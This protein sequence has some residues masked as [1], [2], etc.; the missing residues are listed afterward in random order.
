MDIPKH[1]Q[2]VKLGDLCLSS[3]YGYTT[4]AAEKGDIR[5][6]RTTD[7]A[8]KSQ[9][10]W[11]NVPFA[12]TKPDN[13]EDFLLENGDILISRSGTVGVTSLI[14]T[15]PYKAIFASYLIRFKPVIIDSEYLHYFTK[16]ENYWQQISNN[17]SGNTI[18]NVNATKLS[19]LDIPIPPLAEQKRIVKALAIKL[20]E[21]QKD[22]K[23][24]KNELSKMA[25]YRKGILEHAVTGKLTEAWRVANNL[26]LE[27]IETTIGEVIT[28]ID[29]GTSKSL[30]INKKGTPIIRIPNLIEFQLDLSDMKYTKFSEPEYEK[31]KLRNGEILLI[32]SNGSRNLLG[33]S[34]IVTEKEEGFGFAGYLLRLKPNSS[35]VV[36]KFL[37]YILHSSLVRIQIESKE[38]ASGGVNNINSQEVKTI[39]INLFPLAEQEEIVQQI[40]NLFKKAAEIEYQYSESIQRI[41]KLQQSVLQMAFN[42]QLSNVESNDEPVSILL[43]RI[44]IEKERIEKEIKEIE[45]SKSKTRGKMNKKN[46]EQKFILEILKTADNKTMTVEEL[47]EETAFSKA[48]EVEPFYE[49]LIQLEESKVIK[50]SWVDDK[51]IKTNITLS[52]NAN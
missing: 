20:N 30:N 14:S 16:T 49:E 33:K 51:N 6:V 32:R 38:G 10:D 25:D 21:Y 48:N 9:V 28:S 42:G 4:S 34:S 2:L 3:Q 19:N 24:A 37:N 45:K 46:D 1:W 23:N 52:D 18:S 17:K 26:N 22:F 44:K 15:I 43:E 11:L 27:V 40:E 12:K 50:I 41:E 8:G 13:L 47:W 29:Y 36:P 31:I 35:I 39:K 7:I 5:L